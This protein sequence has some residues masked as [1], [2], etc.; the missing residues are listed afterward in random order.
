MQVYVKPAPSRG[1]DDGQK[2]VVQLQLV[3]SDHSP[4]RK[5]GRPRKAAQILPKS[6]GDD[7]SDDEE[8]LEDG[9]FGDCS[10]EDGEEEAEAAGPSECAGASPAKRRRSNHG[11]S[12]VSALPRNAATA[13]IVDD[14]DSEWI[15]SVPA[16]LPETPRRS[17]RRPKVAQKQGQGQGGSRLGPS[18][19][20]ELLDDEV[21]EISTD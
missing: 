21:I 4:A 18:G 6:K 2:F 17:G 13:V 7:D 15:G 3:P 11:W 1:I 16:A 12:G 5:R 10:G 14:S 20:I 8:E 9:D 19:A